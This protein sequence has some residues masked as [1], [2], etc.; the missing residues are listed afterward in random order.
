MHPTPPP[1]KRPKGQKLL[2]KVGEL[3]RRFPSLPLTELA[4]ASAD[5]S[6]PPA[7]AGTGN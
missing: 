5:M 2:L 3:E 1:K 7:R 6:G 4:T